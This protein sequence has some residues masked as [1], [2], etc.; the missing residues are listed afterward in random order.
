LSQLDLLYLAQ[1]LMVIAATTALLL[2]Y[3]RKRLLTSAVIWLSLL[4][5]FLAI[6]G[7][8]L[9]QLAVAAPS[10]LLGQGLYY[11]LQTAILEVGLAYLFARQAVARA[12]ISV[13]Q[14]PAYGAGLAFWE[15][16]VLLGVPSIVELVAVI[17]TGGAGLPSGSLGQVVQLVAFGT[18]ERVSSILVHFSWGIL[19]VVAAV[20]KKSRFLLVALPMGLIDALVPVAPTLGLA[21]FETLVFALSVLC[22]AVTYL[23]TREGWP[24]FWGAAKG[25]SPSISPSLLGPPPPTL[26]PSAA[27]SLTRPGMIHAQCPKCRAVFEAPWNPFLPHMGPLELRKCPACGKRSFMPSGVADPLTWPP[28]KQR[29]P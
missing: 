1:P 20:S 29:L 12:L 10:D 8:I 5:Y 3:H 4:A 13:E 18:L 16:G 23:M 27:G 25:P 2:L 26:G 7:K 17:S 11:G 9:F 22:L 19:V 21:G 6:G 28:G 14:A 24:T 15:N